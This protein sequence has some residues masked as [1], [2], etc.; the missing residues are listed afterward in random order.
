MPRQRDRYTNRCGRDDDD[1]SQHRAQ[2]HSQEGGGLVTSADGDAD[3]S[4]TAEWSAM[5]SIEN[6][7][8]H[9]EHGTIIATSSSSSSS[10]STTG[11]RDGGDGASG[12][13]AAAGGGRLGGGGGRPAAAEPDPLPTTLAVTVT[14]AAPP[15]PNRRRNHTHSRLTCNTHTAQPATRTVTATATTQPPHRLSH[16]IPEL[17]TRRYFVFRAWG[18]YAPAAAMPMPL[19]GPG[20]E[21]LPPRA[22]RLAVGDGSVRCCGDGD[23]ALLRGDR[24]ASSSDADGITSDGA[25]PSAME[26]RRY[27]EASDAE[28]TAP[29]QYNHHCANDD[30]QWGRDP[31]RR[32]STGCRNVQH[33]RST[34]RTYQREVQ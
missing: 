14:G 33:G 4:H 7:C 9:S 2:I 30:H 3:A 13:A 11:G 6:R 21:P 12:A 25:K 27:S 16:H 18:S 17:D 26:W 32:V 10:C 28:A 29:T 31:G 24:L 15:A 5:S 34:T 20:A 22:M 19:P 23:C 8:R 1:V